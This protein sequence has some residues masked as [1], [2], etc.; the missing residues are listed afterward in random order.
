[1]NAPFFLS[2]FLAFVITLA[3]TAG[4]GLVA[5]RYLAP[6]APLPRFIADTFEFTLAPGWVCDLEETE[7]VCWKGRPPH[8][9]IAVIAMKRRG[10]EDNLAAYD[11]HLRTPKAMES[12]VF[13][14]I[15]GVERRSLAGY[16][17]IQAIHLS[18]EVPNYVTIYLA[19]ATSQVGLVATFSVH[20][21][22]EE[23][24]R[25][26]MEIMMSSLKIH[27]QGL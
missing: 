15:R 17:W 20:K 8:E 6:P 18:S 2:A 12:G 11:K 21:D 27:Q 16:D 25:R 23:E 10:P 14:T 22:H 3:S 4:I 24:A 19:T 26:E 5:G 1:M 9:A 7:H 13:S